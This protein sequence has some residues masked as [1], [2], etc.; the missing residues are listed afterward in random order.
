MNRRFVHTVVVLLTI[1]VSAYAQEKPTPPSKPQT[2]PRV[3]G[4]TSSDTSSRRS[5]Q[6][7]ATRNAQGLP[8]FDLPEFVITGVATIDLPEIDKQSGDEPVHTLELPNPV[9]AARD[10]STVEFVSEEKEGLSL[11]NQPMKSGR[12]QASTGTYFASRFSLWLSKLSPEYRILG[13]LEYGISK[14]YLPFTNRSEAQVNVTG[15]M[16]LRGPAEWYDRA[17]LRGDLG[18]GSETYR[19]YGSPT[20]SAT[21]TVTQFQLAA[22]LD[23]PRELLFNYSGNAGLSIAGFSDSS[24]SVTETQFRL[25]AESNLLVGAVPIDGRIDLSLASVSGS[26]GGSLP[27]LEAAIVM[28]KLWYRGFFV[29]ASGHF[30][31]TQGMLGQKLARLY[32]HIVV[33][34]R[35][36]ENSVASISYLGRAQFNTLSGLIQFHP[37]LSA[38]STVRQSDLP[39]DLVLVLETNW[40][41]L[42]RTRISARYQTVRDYPLY[43]QGGQKGIWTMAY[44]GTTSL[45]T[46]QAQAFAKFAANSYFTMSLEINSTKNSVTQWKIPYLPD[47]RLSG[48]LSVE[49]GSGLRVLPSIT[50]VDRRVINLYLSN[51]LK[52]YFLLGLRGEYSALRSLIVFLDCQNLTDAAYEEWSG[53][54]ATPLIIAAGLSVHW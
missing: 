16:T 44:F 4:V 34:Y 11:P 10:R 1:L 47:F 46:Y 29:Q 17:L 50:F 38:T 32:P 31:F 14:A 40:S 36:L 5:G 39:F 19:F 37:Y 25:G 12:V 3:V 15:D 24:S 33:G 2:E 28:Q 49:I 30:Y 27:Y 26:S 54:R 9:E 21:R 53:Y 52:E 20:P 42:W 35:F 6:D 22:N 43:T 13:D 45:A 41:E 18:Y 51:R 8:K 48:G 7:I 23:S